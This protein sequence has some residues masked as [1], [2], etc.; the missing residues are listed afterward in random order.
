MTAA[1]FDRA[2]QTCI[3]LR[4]LEI[5]V[6]DQIDRHPL[7]AQHDV[8]VPLDLG[9]QDIVDG[10]AGGICCVR[11]AAHR[12]P[13]LAGQM[14]PQ[15]AG[16]VWRE[17][18]APLHQPLHR[19][20]AVAGNEFGC[21]LIHQA[22]A[23]FL[24]VTHMRFDAVVAA[25]HAHDAAL[26]P[27]RGGFFQ[28]PLGQH[29]H[30]LLVGQVQGHGQARQTGTNHHHRQRRLCSTRRH[31]RKRGVWHLKGQ[32]RVWILRLGGLRAGVRPA[33]TQGSKPVH[34]A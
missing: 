18:H 20:R 12:V 25:Q 31:T 27:G 14:Q 23:G 7:L 29:D 2:L 11:N 16:R 8:R 13:A 1:R 5:A 22:G 24:R 10:L 4:A 30:G 32:M 17:R 9:Q 6:G 33:R 19:V 21:A 28:V 26:G 34:C 3:L 15:G